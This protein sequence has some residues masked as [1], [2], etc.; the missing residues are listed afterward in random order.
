M[1]LLKCVHEFQVKAFVKG[2]KHGGLILNEPKPRKVLP[3]PGTL[4]T[5]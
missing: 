5:Y 2:L 1:N 3:Q 4:P